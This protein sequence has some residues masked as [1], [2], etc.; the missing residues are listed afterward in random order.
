MIILNLTGL[1]ADFVG[2]MLLGYDVVRIQRKLRED[3][4]ERLS[5][6]NDLMDQ[7][8]NNVGYAKDLAGKSDWRHFDYDEGMMV[9]LGESFDHRAASDS[10]SAAV[11][12]IGSVGADV[13][14]MAGV[15]AAA[16]EA[17]ERTARLSLRLSYTG[18][19]LILM[20]FAL[21]FYAQL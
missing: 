18:L 9:P 7:N 15:F 4:A 19:A 11:N 10:Y 5:N 16:Y 12:F 6:F 3:A 21:Q 13:Y 1:G 14:K 8:A 20:G 2:V 17:D